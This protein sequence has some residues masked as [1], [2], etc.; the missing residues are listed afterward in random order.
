MKKYHFLSVGVMVLL[1]LLVASGNVMAQTARRCVMV[2]C[3]TQASVKDCCP[4]GQ[5]DVD[6]KVDTKSDS[7][8]PGGVQTSPDCCPA[9]TTGAQNSQNAQPSKEIPA[10]NPTNAKKSVEG[11]KEL[12]K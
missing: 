4:Q 8:C 11:K 1:F 9:N 6:C 5:S 12:T 2:E 7:C 3:D 10:T